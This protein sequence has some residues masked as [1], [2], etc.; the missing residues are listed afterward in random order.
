MNRFIII[1]EYRKISMMPKANQWK[2]ATIMT[3]LFFAPF[4]S[5]GTEAFPSK[6]KQRPERPFAIGHRG[7]AGLLPENTLASFR[8]ALELKVDAI[9]LDVQLSADGEVVVHHNFHLNPDTTRTPDGE[10]LKERGPAIRT[11]TLAE[12]KRFDVGRLKPFS[13]YARRY[14]DQ[15]PADGE[16]I[17]T[18]AEVIS[19][20]KREAGE[21]TELWIEIKTSPEEPSSSPPEALSDAMMKIVDRENVSSRIRVLSFDWRS[22]VHLQKT[23]PG[24]ATLYLS[25]MGGSPDN[26]QAGRPG[27]SPWTAGIDA[28]DHNGSVPRMVKAAGGRIWGTYYK[29]LTE[30]LL[31]EAHRLGLEAGVWTVDKRSE[32]VRMIDMKVDGITTNRPDILLSIPGMR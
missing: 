23:V 7:A 26:I 31:A 1:K 10:W 18:L 25:H 27:I 14:P 28:D 24:I 15:V 20:F 13:P 30:A 11:L 4:C 2:K 8:R 16:R 12:L 32:M 6:E 17:P 19:L 9:E 5:S 21:K 29:E 22:L 3:L